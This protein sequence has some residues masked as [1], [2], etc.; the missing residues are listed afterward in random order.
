MAKKQFNLDDAPVVESQE[1]KVIPTDDVLMEE[2]P[3]TTPDNNGVKGLSVEEQNDPNKIKVTIEDEKTPIVVL[4]G[5][6]SSGKTMT[7]IRL[8]RYLRDTAFDVY[9]IRTFRPAADAHYKK[10]CDDFNEMVTSENAAQSTSQISFMLLQVSQKGRPICQILEAP[11]EHYFIPKDKTANKSFPRYINSIKSNNNRK[12]W[13]FIVEPDWEDDT[14][15][16][17]YAERIKQLKMNMNPRDKAIFLYNKVDKTPF[18][19]SRGK[20]RIK[21]AIQSV[22]NQYKGIYEPFRN[23]NPITSFFKEYNCEFVPFSTGDY[24]ETIDGGIVYEA[25][26]DEYPRELWRKILSLIKG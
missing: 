3:D 2:I 25:G 19:I 4:F 10:M 21:Q 1:E 26:P 17:N 16:L 20:V 7:L 22:G 11:G 6:P 23:Q 8:T 9:P 5:P 15:R 13:L 14:D 18:V 24:N 12:I